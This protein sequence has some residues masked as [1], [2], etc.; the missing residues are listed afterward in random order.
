MKMKDIE[1]RKD[2]QLLVDS[3]YEKVNA[4]ALLGPVFNEVA[5]VNWETHLPVMYDFWST[6][7]LGDRSYKGVPFTAHIP[8]P[9]NKTHFDRWITLFYETLDEHFEGINANEARSRATNIASVFQHKL[10]GMHPP[11]ESLPATCPLSGRT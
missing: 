9:I 5:K 4:D 10:E 11:L 8:L 7:L 1:S 6:L 2:I 3:F